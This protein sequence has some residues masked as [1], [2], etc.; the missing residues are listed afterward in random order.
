M[1]D[2]LESVIAE[3][4]DTFGE[5]TGTLVQD[6]T[7][8]PFTDAVI[9][10]RRRTPAGGNKDVEEIAL[11]VPASGIPTLTASP[12]QATRLLFTGS[13]ESWQVTQAQPVMRGGTTEG[14]RLSLRTWTDF[15]P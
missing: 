12:R 15:T 2:E 4:V 8:Y 1:A 6:G 5:S 3:L 11:L 10:S 9:T 13:A 14:W 7:D